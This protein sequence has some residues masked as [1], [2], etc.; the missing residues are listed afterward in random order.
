MRQLKPKR[1]EVGPDKLRW[2]CDPS[3]FDFQCTIDI[4]PLHSFVGQD[5]AIKAIEFGLAIE[6]GGYNVYVAGLTGTGKTT[7]VKEYIQRSISVRTKQPDGYKPEDWCYVYSFVDPDRPVIVSLPQAKGKAFKGQIATL[8]QDIKDGVGRAFSGEEYEAAKKRII[9]EG[10]GQQRQIVESLNAEAHKQRFLLELSPTGAMVIPVANGKAMSQED[11][12]ALPE[13]TRKDIDSRRV[14]FM[15]KVESAF[16]KMRDIQKATSDKLQADDKKIGEFTISRL[17]RELTSQHQDSEGI[18]T[19]LTGLKNYTLNNLEVFKQQQEEPP[20][21]QHGQMPSPQAMWGR[22]PLL[23]FEVNVFV[24]NSQTVG[25]PV[26]EE[27]NPTFGNIFGKI[28]RRFLLG[29]YL[30]DHTMLKPGALSLASGG[31]LLVNVRDVLTRPGVW[32]GLKRAIR[33]KE[34]RIE[35]PFEQFGLIAPQGMRPQPMPVQVKVVLIGDSMI[36]DML[37]A[38]DEDFWEIFKVK[39]DFDFQIDRTSANM[40]AYACFVSKCCQEENIRHFDRSGVAKLIEFG[41]RA[42]ADQE[43]LSS[44][45]SQLKDILLEA[46]YWAGQA[47]AT[48]VTAEH[49]QKAVQEKIY[50]HNLVDERIRELIR[51]GTLMIDVE[52]MEAG[53]VNGLSV[54]TLGGIMFGRPSRITAKT[55]LGRSG[56]VNI[57]RESQMSGRIHDKGVLI[58]SGYLGAKYAQDKP[59]TLSASLCF[60]Q[61]Y[62]GIEGDSASS[63]E[64]YAILSSLSGVPIRQGI[65]VTGS[66]NQKGEIQPIGGVNHKIEGFFQVCQA[67]GLT[68]EQGVMIPHKNL[69]NL[70]LRED[71]VDAVRQGKFY[72]YSVKTIDEGVEV[73]T[74]VKAGQRQADGSYPEGTINHAVSK[75]LKEMAEA[76]KGFS[77]TEEKAGKEGKAA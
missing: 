67:K 45:F 47:G 54:Y 6:R 51:K 20:G 41:A 77:A 65:A 48:L 15:K 25:P 71:V 29:G 5:R 62:E 66:V 75:R 4:P 74:G 46:D 50:R 2:V 60:E 56:I 58:L 55:F 30:S 69:S 35:D 22:E 14:E 16:E 73:L 13:E 11:Y 7:V 33:T 72:I 17:F 3:L 27:S 21:H 36:Y 19:Y 24:D 8:L 31:Y 68:G 57:E 44:R 28:E 63:T 34:V 32:E 53:Q 61:S 23:P 70:M 1:F 49:V 52:G 12:L 64:L 39:A 18:M 43:K 10:Q 59:L 9:E 76:L 37:A 40:N 42:V 38:L 26:I